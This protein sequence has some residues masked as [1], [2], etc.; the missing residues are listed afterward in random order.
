M[1][2][3][4]RLFSFSVSDRN[5]CRCRVFLRDIFFILSCWA[6]VDF[7]LLKLYFKHREKVVL[8]TENPMKIRHR[9]RKQNMN[10]IPSHMK[11]NITTR[12]WEEMWERIIAKPNAWNCIYFCGKLPIKLQPLRMCIRWICLVAAATA[13]VVHII[14]YSFVFFLFLSD[15]VFIRPLICAV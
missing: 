11:L 14:F 9:N 13:V 8:K 12:E 15:L 1:T 3:V 7:Y 5:A 10:N 4:F 2:W 6:Y